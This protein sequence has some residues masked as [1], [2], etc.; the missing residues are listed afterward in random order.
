VWRSLRTLVS[1][2]RLAS[3]A[4]SAVTTS[5][6]YVAPSSFAYDIAGGPSAVVIGDRR[7]DR[8]SPAG[9]WRRSAQDPPL[10]QPVPPWTAVRNAYLVDSTGSAWRVTFFDPSLTAWFAITLDRS[11]L[12]TLDLRMTTTAHF[13]HDV[14]GPFNSRLRLE[15]P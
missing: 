2:E 4:R 13:M 1:H 12:R 14:Y 15:P 6:R 11:T 8:G 10:R 5:W 7:W 3:G 9:G